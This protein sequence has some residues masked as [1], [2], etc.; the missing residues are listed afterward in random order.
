M[1]QWNRIISTA[2]TIIICV[3]CCVIHA[4]A[5]DFQTE[6]YA[7]EKQTELWESFDLSPLEIPDTFH[8]KIVSFD[9]SS[10]GYYAIAL[11]DEQLLILNSELTPLRMFRFHVY[12]D[13]CIEW[14]NN[15]LALFDVR[16]SRIYVFSIEGEQLEIRYFADTAASANETGKLLRRTS[17]VRGDVEHYVEKSGNPIFNFLQGY[18]YEQLIRREAGVEEILY[19]VSNVNADHYLIW[20]LVFG[21][22]LLITIFLNGLIIPIIVAKKS[23]TARKKALP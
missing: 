5:Y 8:N 13:Y 9:I 12:G 23:K 17:V 1:S 10:E 2:L 21:V 16:G 22:F 6:M 4:N 14:E 19:D 7:P 3:L 15:N 18:S 20:V 11:K